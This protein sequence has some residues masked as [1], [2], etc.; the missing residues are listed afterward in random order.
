MSMNVMEQAATVALLKRASAFK[1]MQKDIQSGDLTSAQKDL[2]SFDKA[3]KAARALLGAKPGG[4]TPAKPTK[5]ATDFNQ[6]LS[7]VRTG[8]LTSAQAALDALKA[9]RPV[10]KP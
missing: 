6:F 9:D 8:D 5:Y 3:M 2:E 10:K 7:A 1:Q 4:A